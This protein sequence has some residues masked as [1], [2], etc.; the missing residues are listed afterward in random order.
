[1]GNIS[2]IRVGGV[3]YPLNDSSVNE[4]LRREVER[5]YTALMT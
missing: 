5:A 4:E 1:M 3:T 2:K